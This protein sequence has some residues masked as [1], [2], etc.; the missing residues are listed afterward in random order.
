[1]SK[2]ESKP[3]P[4]PK[5]TAT[6]KLAEWLEAMTAGAALMAKVQAGTEAARAALVQRAVGELTGKFLDL[7]EE[8]AAK[9]RAKAS[10]PV[11]QYILGREAILEELGQPAEQWRFI[12]RLSRHSGG[13][14]QT[15]EGGKTVAESSALRRWWTAAMAV[16]GESERLAAG[17]RLAGEAT[18]PYGR[19]EAAPEVGGGVKKKRASR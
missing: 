4:S 13:P 6:D 5:K 18:H 11:P 7:Q 1:M 3:P 17:R 16:Y 9:A 12:L 15:A 2:P 14:I 19:G 10:P 8:A